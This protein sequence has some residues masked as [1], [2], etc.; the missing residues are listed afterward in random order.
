[1]CADRTPPSFWT[2]GRA[3][4]AV[5]EVQSSAENSLVWAQE[6]LAGV[7]LQAEAGH[8]IDLLRQA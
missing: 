6:S 4:A 5:G 3:S 7:K 8:E 2:L 1:M